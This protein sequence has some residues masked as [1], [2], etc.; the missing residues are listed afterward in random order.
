MT[1]FSPDHQLARRAPEPAAASE[2]KVRGLLHDL[3]HQMM[4][5][6]LLADSVR[7]DSALSADSRQRMDLVLQ[8]MFRIVDII[9]DAVPTETATPPGAVDIRA[10]AIEVANLAHL[11][12][13]TEVTVQAGRPAVIRISAALIWRILANLVDNAVRAAGSE[14]H[15]DIRIEQ[16]LDTVLEITDD[17]PGL[18]GGPPGLAG[19]GLTVVRQL[20]D[21]A[22]GRLEVTD[23]PAGGARVR[24]TFGLDREYQMLPA[25]AGPWH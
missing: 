14:G 8:E 12:Y 3:G 11:A 7:G 24:V 16:E 17:G 15:V 25:G 10:L 22:D 20:L 18:C 9:A 13:N 6:S 4:T 21:S 5:L 23:V 19:L 2:L 1:G